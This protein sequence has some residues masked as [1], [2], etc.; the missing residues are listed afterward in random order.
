[1]RYIALLR[2]VNVGG[3]TVKMDRLRALFEALGYTAVTTYI[4]SGNVIFE[5][6]QTDSVML[7]QQIEG[8]LHEALGYAVKTFLRTSAELAAVASYVPFPSEELAADGVS[9]YVTFFQVEPTEEMRQ[10]VL[11][12]QT[13]TDSFHIHGRELYWLLH[14]KLSE[15][16][17]FSGT[18]LEKAIALPG[19]QRNITTVRKLAEKYR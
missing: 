8:H 19:T 5:T 9:L 2:G 18:A 14:T 15:S 12:L 17:Y 3:H 11:G 13:A 10:R 1:M 7:E 6:D 4:A 16:S